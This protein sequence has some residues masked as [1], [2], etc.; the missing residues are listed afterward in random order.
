MLSTSCSVPRFKFRMYKILILLTTFS[1]Q[2]ANG[3]TTWAHERGK[4]DYSGQ[5]GTKVKH[6]TDQ[7]KV[8]HKRIRIPR[9][10]CS[11]DPQYPTQTKAKP[12]NL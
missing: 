12:N 5:C 3:S 10:A 6:K 4:S 2:S 11:K 9:L 8:K 7:K 1:T